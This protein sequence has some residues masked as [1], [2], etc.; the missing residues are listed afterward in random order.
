M[1]ATSTAPPASANCSSLPSASWVGELVEVE[2]TF[3]AGPAGLAR[4]EAVVHHPH[5]PGVG[6]ELLTSRAGVVLSRFHP[7]GVRRFCAGAFKRGAQGDPDGVVGAV[8]IVGRVEQ[9]VVRA[10]LDHRWA[11]DD[12]ALPRLV[13]GDQSIGR[14]RGRQALGGEGLG[15]DRRWEPTA[16]PVALPQE[17]RRGAVDEDAGVNGAPFVEGTDERGG[18]VIAKGPGRA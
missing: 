14:S 10:G 4:Q 3:S 1:T 7:R 8:P 6:E 17:V 5:A 12:R 9:F 11:L 13:V 15:V 18:G 16:I 2:A